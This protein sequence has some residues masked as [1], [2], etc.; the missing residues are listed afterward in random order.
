MT[1]PTDP[2]RKERREAAR[3]QREQQEREAA[4]R[5]ARTRRLQLLGAIVAVVVV[6]VGIIAIATSGG[7]K[8][9]KVVAGQPAPNAATAN[10]L[11]QGIPQHGLVLGNPKAKLTL[12]EFADLQ[13]PICR[14]YSASVFPTLIERYVRPGKVKMI[15]RNLTFIGPDSV[16][17]ARVA[18]AA[19]A[20]NRLWTFA[21]L[22]Y[23]DQLEEN[24]GYV[25]DDYLRSIVKGVGGLDEARVLRE[26]SGAAVTS[27]LSAAQAQADKLGVTGTPTV[28]IGPDE[29]HLT[30]I[31]ATTIAPSEF[32]GPIDKALAG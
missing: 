15:F 27:L 23:D 32:T 29:R 28:F 11:L 1:K 7:T 2:T 30:R 8:H 6:V 13:C 26:R 9:P 22:F 14:E 3:A 4:A 10:E 12:V 18:G 17:A 19:A 16:R 20:Q 25:T 21:D 24:S 5:A 31:D